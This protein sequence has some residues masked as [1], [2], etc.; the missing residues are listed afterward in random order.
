MTGQAEEHEPRRRLEELLEWID[1]GLLQHPPAAEHAEPEEKHAEPEEEHALPFEL[2]TAQQSTPATTPAEDTLTLW[3]IDCLHPKHIAALFQFIRTHINPRSK[4]ENERQDV[5]HLKSIKPI[6]PVFHP[7][8]SFLS[9]SP[10]LSQQT[11]ELNR[12]SMTIE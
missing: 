8:C 3:I 9:L 1:G 11:P 4:N 6:Q 2:V 10:T 12:N 5:R 7:V